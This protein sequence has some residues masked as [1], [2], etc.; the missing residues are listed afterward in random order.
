MVKI[1]IKIGKVLLELGA[2]FGRNDAPNESSVENKSQI[3]RNW[4]K[5]THP[6]A[7][8]FLKTKR[9]KFVIVHKH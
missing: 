9:Y 5:R 4:F 3:L 7:K 1:G 2:N 8:M 6:G